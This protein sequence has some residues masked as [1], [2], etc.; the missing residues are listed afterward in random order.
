MYIFQF[1]PEED[2]RLLT[3]CL[4]KNDLIVLISRQKS[5]ESYHDTMEKPYENCENNSHHYDGKIQIVAVCYICILCT[6]VAQ[7]A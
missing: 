1:S 5:A 6:Y 4:T 7:W 2:Q 3:F